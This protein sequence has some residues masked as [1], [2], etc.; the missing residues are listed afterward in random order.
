MNNIQKR[1]TIED[2]LGD[3]GF[4]LVWSVEDHWADVTAYEITC[5]STGKLADPGQPMF[6][7]ADWHSLP[8]PVES[9]EQAEVYLS[10]FVK[11]DGC[12][13][14]DQG[15]PHWCGARGFKKHC[16]LLRYIYERAFDLMDREPDEPWGEA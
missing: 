8:D 14:P 5:R 9:H 16:A 6:N 12:S 2:V 7:R 1:I 15:R 13:E 10:G 11:W 3:Y 4:R